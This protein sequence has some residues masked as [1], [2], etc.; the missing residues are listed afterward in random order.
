MTYKSH[1]PSCLKVIGI[2][3]FSLVPMAP[4]LATEFV[5]PGETLAFTHADGGMRECRIKDIY[6]GESPV[7]GC[8]DLFTVWRASQPVL[9]NPVDYIATAANPAAREVQAAFSNTIG[10]SPGN[11]GLPFYATGAVYN[12]FQIDDPL[13]YGGVVDVQFAI[14]YSWEGGIYGL[15]N[16]DG[17]I[18]LSM[19]IDDITD[20]PDKPVGVGSLE[21]ASRD[22]QGDQ[23]FTDIAAGGTP[24]DRN[25][26]TASFQIKLRGGGIYR[27]WFKAEAYGAPLILTFVDSSIRGRWSELS[28]TVA[29]NDT[30][31]LLQILDALKK[32]D[33]DI[34]RLHSTPTGRRPGF[35][36]RNR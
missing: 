21:L 8:G 35:P 32:H 29:E 4:A 36:I 33:L 17:R 31:L 6:I 28:V 5:G 9:P 18:S 3:L 2:S 20:G 19:E 25:N 15:A 30:L 22:R 26:D 14:K 34:K 12:D 10:V 24:Y 1:I 16:Y 27:I 11:I 13:G 23:G 7:L